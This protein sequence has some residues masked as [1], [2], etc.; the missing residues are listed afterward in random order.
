MPQYGFTYHVS[1]RWL[2]VLRPHHPVRQYYELNIRLWTESCTHLLF[3]TA[4]LSCDFQVLYAQGQL[5][6]TRMFTIKPASAQCTFCQQQQCRSSFNAGEGLASRYPKINVSSYL[7]NAHTRSD[8]SLR[9]FNVQRT[10]C[11]VPCVSQISSYPAR[12]EH[13]SALRGSNTCRR[14]TYSTNLCTAVSG[15]SQEACPM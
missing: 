7:L 8:T 14:I 2:Q 6:A 10:C 5:Q 4:M 11:S 15:C 3:K 13:I 12:V 1:S 9:Y